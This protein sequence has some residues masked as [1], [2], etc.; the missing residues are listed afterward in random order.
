MGCAF[1]DEE[2]VQPF[3]CYFILIDSCFA[4][5]G[6]SAKTGRALFAE[7]QQIMTSS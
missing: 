6:D 5:A 7:K 1:S 3:L 2:G 4:A